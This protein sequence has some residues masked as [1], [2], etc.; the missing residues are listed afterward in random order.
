MIEIKGLTKYYGK[1]RALDDVN[2][3]LP[4]GRIIGLLGKNGAGKST[5]MRSM[6]GFLRYQ[7]EISFAASR[8]CRATRASST[9]SPS[10]PT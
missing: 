4:R 7:G 9:A 10:F 5:L 2:L 6:L 1:F 3:T 8:W